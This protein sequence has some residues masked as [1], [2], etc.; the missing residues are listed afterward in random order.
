MSA[1][2]CPSSPRTP[3][4]FT[5]VKLISFPRL[6]SAEWT[7]LMKVPYLSITRARTIACIGKLNTIGIVSNK[8][9]HSSSPVAALQ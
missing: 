8:S 4:W 9:M 2:A 6:L 1:A 7:T 3:I 5:R